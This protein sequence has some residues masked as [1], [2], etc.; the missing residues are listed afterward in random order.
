[1]PDLISGFDLVHGD[2]HEYHFLQLYKK[3]KK[4]K[5]NILLIGP[6]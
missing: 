6:R 2:H 1:M 5:K 4:K 3:K